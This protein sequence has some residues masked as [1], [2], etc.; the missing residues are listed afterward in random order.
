MSKKTKI[1][2]EDLDAFY[3]AVAG[4][5][6]LTQKKVKLAPK[7]VL[8]RT[9]PLNTP[10]D[11][12]DDFVLNETASL[13]EVDSE[14]FLSYKQPGIADK[15]LRKL[16]K[17]QYNVEAILDLHGET[18]EG[19]RNAVIHFLKQCLS[20]EIRVVLI[21]HGK[22]HHSQKPILKNKLNLWLRDIQNVLA[23]CSAAP[24]HGNRG[25]IYV[26]LKQLSYTQNDKNKGDLF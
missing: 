4:T 15:F 7:K 12:H 25:A 14:S 23:F 19:A 18:S 17:G 3:Q 5:K 21:I 16:R 9:Q 2:K 13:A 24:L 1:T 26:L 6:P 20:Q 11:P 8:V 22:G 10:Q